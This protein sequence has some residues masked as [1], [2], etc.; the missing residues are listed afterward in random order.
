MGLDG[1]GSDAPHGGHPRRPGRRGP[2]GIGSSGDA[3]EDARVENELA[4]LKKRIAPEK[5]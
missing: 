1:P 4:A 5:T 2:R 3:D